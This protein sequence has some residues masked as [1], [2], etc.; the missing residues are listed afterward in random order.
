V[1][2]LPG[3]GRLTLTRAI[4]AAGGLGGLAI[5]ERVDLTRMIG[6]DRQATIMLDYRAIAEGTQPDVFLKR[7]DVI[8]IGTNFWAFPLAVIRG[9][10]GSTTGSGSCSTGTSVTTSSALR[11]PTSA[12]RRFG[13][14]GARPGVPPPT[15]PRGGR[16]RRLVLVRIPAQASP[17]RAPRSRS[18]G[19][20][21]DGSAL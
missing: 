9:G 16:A 8:N 10:S 7:D 6:S 5:P 18:H 19:T 3:I 4:V 14:P 21:A 15:R 20:S 12:D 11:R 2:A 1:Y 13:E 17:V